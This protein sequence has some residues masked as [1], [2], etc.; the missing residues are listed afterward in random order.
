MGPWRHAG[1]RMDRRGGCERWGRER[2]RSFLARTLARQGGGAPSR[3]AALDTGLSHGRAA[4]GEA[5]RREEEGAGAE[6]IGEEERVTG[7]GCGGG[8]RRYFPRA[9]PGGLSG[10]VDKS[11][12]PREGRAPWPGT[13]VQ[14]RSASHDQMATASNRCGDRW[15][16]H[17]IYL[18]IYR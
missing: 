3:R 16:G 17:P 6:G 13:D 18:L 5:T 9:G 2:R 12:G 15:G 10:P 1:E 11:L 4:A 7:L 8:R 14:D